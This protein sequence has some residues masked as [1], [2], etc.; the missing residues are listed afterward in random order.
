MELVT[1]AQ[2]VARELL[3]G[4]LPRRWRH[5]ESAAT[6]AVRIV[7]MVGPDGELLIAAVVLHDVGYAPDLAETGFH[8][9]DGALYLRRI[10]ASERLCALVA[11]HSAARV[12]AEI[13]GLADQLDDFEDERTP[14]RDALWYC[15]MVTGPDGQRFT[16]NQR[17][18]EIT[19]RYG[20]DSV[21]GRFLV[22]ARDELR[23]AVERTE[24]RIRAGFSQPR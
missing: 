2:A 7:D 14:V 3:A 22:L 15:D 16:F 18:H 23:A 12:E 6:E 13:R 19:E 20:P 8:P 24:E 21:T 11:H 17:L 5:V 1:W 9:L 10:G 4:V